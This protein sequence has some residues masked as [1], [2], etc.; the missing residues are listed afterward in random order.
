M[1]NIKSYRQSLGLTQS[2]LADMLNVVP[3]TVTQW[4]TGERTPHIKY[5]KKMATI[6]GCT[7]DSLIG[8]EKPKELHLLGETFNEHEQRILIDVVKL[9]QNRKED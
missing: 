3:S 1:M 7:V 2:A 8:Q 4:E 5:I 6:F 9:I